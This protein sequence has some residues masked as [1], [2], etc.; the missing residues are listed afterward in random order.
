MIH[1]NIEKAEPIMSHENILE[2]RVFELDIQVVLEHALLEPLVITAG[3]HTVQDILEPILTCF[4]FWIII[5]AAG[6]ADEF[7]FGWPW[8][9]KE[10][11]PGCHVAFGAVLV[12]HVGLVNVDTAHFLAFSTFEKLQSGQARPDVVLRLV[13]QGHESRGVRLQALLVGNKGQT[14][15]QSL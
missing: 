7:P 2:S 5:A 12:T 8:N 13:T 4:S 9:G 15:Y 6:Q 10:V 3:H 14:L 11:L 1:M